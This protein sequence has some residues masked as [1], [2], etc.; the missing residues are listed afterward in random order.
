MD[1]VRRKEVTIQYTFF[2][3]MI[4][5]VFLTAAFFLLSLSNDIVAGSFMENVRAFYQHSL[6]WVILFMAVLMPVGAYFIANRL[7]R[8]IQTMQNSIDN[9]EKRTRIFN[10]LL[11]WPFV[12]L[13]IYI[14]IILLGI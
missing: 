9:E 7:T 8:Q 5:F 14:G 4:S 2:S 13:L 6:F 11:V 10:R 3:S 1:K 12:N